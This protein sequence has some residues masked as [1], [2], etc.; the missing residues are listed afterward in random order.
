MHSSM[1]SNVSLLL[2]N[3]I[4]KEYEGLRVPGQDVINVVNGPVLCFCFFLLL[5]VSTVAS[6]LSGFCLV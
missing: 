4:P 6:R 2:N 5:N 3:A 1:P